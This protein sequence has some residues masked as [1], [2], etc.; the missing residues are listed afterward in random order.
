MIVVSFYKFV[1]IADPTSVCRT[2]EKACLEQHAKGTVLVASEGINAV[3]GH[4]SKESLEAVVDFMM[5][6]PELREVRPTWSTSNVNHDAFDRLI[7]RVRGEIVNL[8]QPFDF[9]CEEIP[10]ISPKEWELL[11]QDPNT[12]IVD[13]R[14]KYEV[15]LGRF[16]NSIHP[17]T[18]SF[19]TFKSWAANTDRKIR[20]QPTAIYCTGG[21]RC[22]K[23]AQ[24][25]KRN[26]FHNVC[27]LDQ[28]I[29]GYF[30]SNADLSRWEGECFVFDK[31]V[32]VTPLLSQGTATQ[33][34]ACR[35]PLTVR[36][37]ESKHY[38]EGVSCSYCH[39][40]QTEMRRAGLMERVRQVSLASLRNEKHLGHPQE[41][42]KG[43]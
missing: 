24:T 31:R 2:I 32:S 38:V 42:P 30:D 3:L 16:S 8:D 26:G 10:H 39:S 9:T 43:R 33:C 25:L 28:G 12:T 20:K 21:I 36:D 11:I 5:S 15:R 14:N 13:V 41:K 34:Y 35:R 23:A 22:E 29:L 27:Q 4:K 7:V 40:G 1:Q 6:L 37:R 17:N 18:T 19:S